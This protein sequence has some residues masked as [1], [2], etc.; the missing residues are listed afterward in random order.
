MNFSA[1]RLSALTLLALAS[2]SLTACGGFGT[3][4]FDVQSRLAQL[5]GDIKVCISKLVPKPNE[6]RTKAQIARVISD[7][8]ISEASKTSCGKRLINLYESQKDFH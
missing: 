4:R 7:L 1:L 5:P 2:L 3:E 8:R 6:I